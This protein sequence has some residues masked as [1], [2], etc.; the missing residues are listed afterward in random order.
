MIPNKLRR[1]ILQALPENF[2]SLIKHKFPNFTT[3]T[4]GQI[5]KTAETTKYYITV[6]LY[7]RNVLYAA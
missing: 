2:H 4:E 7:N 6:K 3:V 1:V 5:N